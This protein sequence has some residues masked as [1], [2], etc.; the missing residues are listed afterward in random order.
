MQLWIFKSS[1]PVV[2]KLRKPEKS[3]PRQ[4][5]RVAL[6]P[7]RRS[8]ARVWRESAKKGDR[9][10]VPVEPLFSLIMGIL[11]LLV[12]RPE[13]AVHRYMNVLFSFI[14]SIYEK[15]LKG[16]SR[17]ACIYVNGIKAR[18]YTTFCLCLGRISLLI[19]QKCISQIKHVLSYF[20]ISYISLRVSMCVAKQ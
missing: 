10:Q 16:T 3:P 18:Q 6:E 7:L 17:N 2:L 11:I 1:K 5:W 20:S 4:G 8:A 14:S 15:P 13:F 9:M 19:A 12:P